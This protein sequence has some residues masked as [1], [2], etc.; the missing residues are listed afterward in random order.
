MTK[1]VRKAAPMRNVSKKGVPTTETG[2]SK[3]T[4]K[5]SAVVSMLERRNGSTLAELAVS[6]GWQHHS[7][8]GF[9]SGT[10]K[11]KLGREIVTR[12]VNGERRYSIEG[13][14]AAS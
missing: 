11:K 2:T 14:G 5:T 9:L 3:Q 4:T 13:K 7:V 1:Q 10:V 8:R 6:T 12:I